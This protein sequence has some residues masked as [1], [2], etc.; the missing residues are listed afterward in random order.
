MSGNTGI[1]STNPG[2]SLDVQGTVRAQ[3][4][5]G[6]NPYAIL[7]DQETSGTAGGTGTADSAVLWNGSNKFVSTSPPTND[8]GADGDF[9]FQRE[10]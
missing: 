4:F 9:W 2:A 10:A 3:G 6:S 8:Q 1:G 7:E 5:L